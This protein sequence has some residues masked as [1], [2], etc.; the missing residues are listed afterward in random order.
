MAAGILLLAGA[1]RTQG[2]A[3]RADER[4]RITSPQI[5]ERVE[6]PV[7]V[8]W[9][10]RDM[11]GERFGVF[12]DVSPMPPL[13]PLGYFARDDTSCVRSMGCP[14]VTYLEQRG[15][16]VTDAT[17]FIVKALADTRPYSRR[18]APDRHKV[19]I[20][21]LDADGVRTSEAAFSV[22][23]IVKRDA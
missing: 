21:L 17:T 7:T 8:D 4:V 20:A 11:R 19:T 9:T 1:C 15:I 22:D 14:D 13:E 18:T 12:V 6:L 23:F 16:H 3:F 10:A 2:L 5:N